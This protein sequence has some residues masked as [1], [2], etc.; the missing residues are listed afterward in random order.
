MPDPQRDS[1][2]VMGLAEAGVPA[3]RLESLDEIRRA[4]QPP[5]APTQKEQPADDT[6]PFRPVLR[7]PTAVLSIL[8]DGREEG[9]KIRL[10]RDITVI[11]RT[12]GD[13]IIPHDN[14]MSGKHAAIQ[15]ESAKGRY[16]WVLVD[17]GSTNG[18]FVRASSTVM[19][20]GQEIMIGGRRYRFDAA[21]GAAAAAAAAEAATADASQP[22]GTRGW[23][24]VKTSDLIPSLVELSSQGKEGQRLLLNQ[25]ENW[26]G[27]DLSQC[28]VVLVN[29]LLVSPRHARLYRDAKGVWHLDNA[30]SRNGTWIR[31]TRMALDGVGMF[32][33]GEQRFL[34]KTL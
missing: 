17:L 13:V 27:R 8:D 29:D 10:R 18:T 32:Q 30:G 24:T 23:Q 11:G 7:P 26:I 15:R 1:F 33:L 34:L 12:E 25:E 5:R 3:T 9:E 6:L 19:R 20:H 16:R 4:T 31:I 22:A 2:V 14:A 21:Q 28:S